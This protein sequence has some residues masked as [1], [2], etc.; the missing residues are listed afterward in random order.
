MK[1]K[2]WSIFLGLLFIL[3]FSSS[4]FTQER[5][6]QVTIIA[7]LNYIFE[8]GS[9]ADYMAMGNDFPVTSSHNTPTFGI[10]YTRFFSKKIGFEVDFRYLLS[11]KVTL[12][13]PSDNDEIE[14]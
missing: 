2:I 14:I 13:D 11:S 4:A 1:V 6:N 3:F 5:K 12:I 7:G 9:E 10:S 8:Y